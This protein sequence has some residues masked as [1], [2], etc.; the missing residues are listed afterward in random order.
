M[1]LPSVELE[2]KN[3]PENVQHP[4]VS[5]DAVHPTN[6][7]L[8][9][10][11][12]PRGLTRMT[13][14]DARRFEQILKLPAPPCPQQGLNVAFHVWKSSFSLHSRPPSGSACQAQAYQMSAPASCRVAIG[15]G[16]KAQPAFKRR[17]RVLTILVYCTALLQARATSEG[18]HDG[19]ISGNRI[20]HVPEAQPLINSLFKTRFDKSCR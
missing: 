18:A 2:H 3:R 16:H 1:N 5:C 9:I 19:H 6:R 13:A 20:G 11:G 7:P 12:D 10:T 17:T 15:W 4:P 14:Q 8:T